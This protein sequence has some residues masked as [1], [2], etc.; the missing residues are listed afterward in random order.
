MGHILNIE[1]PPASPERLAMAGRSNKEFR[2]AEVIKRNMKIFFTSIFCGFL[3]CGSAV[4]ILGDLIDGRLF[5][6]AIVILLPAESIFPLLPSS[7]SAI[8]ACFEED[9]Y[10]S[11]HN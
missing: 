9:C 11:S 3:F 4:H 5:S 2:T 1:Y 8:N 10:G 7:F 6:V